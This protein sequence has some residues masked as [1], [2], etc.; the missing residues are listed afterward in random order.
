MKNIILPS[1]KE[2]NILSF[3]NLLPSCAAEAHKI[4]SFSNIIHPSIE[5]GGKNHEKLIRMIPI[6]IWLY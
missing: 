6:H 4:F 2:K 3:V 1:L 5:E